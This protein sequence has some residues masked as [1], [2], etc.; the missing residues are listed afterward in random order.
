MQEVRFHLQVAPGHHVVEHAHALEQGDV[1]EGAGDALGGRLVGTHLVARLP[2]VDD[3]ALLRVVDAV[4]DVEH[5]ALAG[6][7]RADD[8]ADLAALDLEADAGE[9]LD[10]AETQADVLDAQE[11]AFRGGPGIAPAL[12]HLAERQHGLVAGVEYV[13]AERFL[14]G[15]LAD[16][17]AGLGRGADANRAEA[18]LDIGDLAALGEAFPGFRRDHAI[19]VD[20]QEIPTP[21]AVGQAFVHDVVEG[22]DIGIDSKGRAAKVH[23]HRLDGVVENDAFFEHPVIHGSSS[24]R[25]V[26]RGWLRR[27]ASRPRADRS[28]PS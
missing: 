14:L 23:F 7:V 11:S 9:R 27:P 8:G 21:A 24:R 16:L 1:L 15:A 6:A 3:G 5:R 17:L 28:W 12:A 13:G 10:A 4:D 19:G 2:E 26:M 22:V 25:L 20:H 18:V